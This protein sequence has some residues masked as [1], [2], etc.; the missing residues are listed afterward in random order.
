MAGKLTLIKKEVIT[1]ATSSITM[2]GINT[3]DEHWLVI[4]NLRTDGGTEAR[5]RLTVS[6]SANT[7]AEYDYRLA[8]YRVENT[9]QESFSSN[10]T[11]WRILNTTG[12]PDGSHA[13]SIVKLSNLNNSSEFSFYN[14]EYTGS[15]SS[16]G[17]VRGFY[18][19]G[20]HTVAT[21]CDGVH[22]FMNGSDDMI[23]GTFRLYRLGI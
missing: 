6:G 23:D 5:L 7:S 11:S 10:Q 13:N 21:A 4:N 18:G 3:N 20:F 15:E 12:T 19:A 16:S 9:E 8:R 1:T 2:T 17:Y 14:L 22:I